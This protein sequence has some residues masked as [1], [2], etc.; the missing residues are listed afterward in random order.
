[1]KTI[2]LTRRVEDFAVFAAKALIRGDR[3][4]PVPKKWRAIPRWWKT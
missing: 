3:I 4:G 2:Q 1:M